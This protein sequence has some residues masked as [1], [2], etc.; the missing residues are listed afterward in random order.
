MNEQAPE[1]KG[2]LNNWVS[3]DYRSKKTYDITTNSVTIGVRNI[4]R[5][6]QIRMPVQKSFRR[7][8]YAALEKMPHRD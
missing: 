2:I 3:E 7:L 4:I 6:V 5:A 1:S 8:V